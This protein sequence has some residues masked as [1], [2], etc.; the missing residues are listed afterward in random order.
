MLNTIPGNWKQYAIRTNTIQE[1]MNQLKQ[2]KSRE[3]AH[4]HNGCEKSWFLL[5]LGLS[6]RLTY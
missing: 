3:T 2:K 6:V 4:F 5:F 1:P